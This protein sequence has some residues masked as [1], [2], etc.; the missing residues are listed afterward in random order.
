MIKTIAVEVD[1][2]EEATHYCFFPAMYDQS[3][4]YDALEIV[5]WKYDDF[6]RI[7]S[8]DCS[9]IE[10]QYLHELAVGID[11]DLKPITELEK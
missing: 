4:R 2:P 6:G 11:Y 10:W 8:W 3:G 1:V 5:F 7:M 9:D